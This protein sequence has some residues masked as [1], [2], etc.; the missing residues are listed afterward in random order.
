MLRTN[1]GRPVEFKAELTSLFPPRTPLTVELVLGGQGGGGRHVPMKLIDGAYRAVAVPFPEAKLPPAVK[2]KVERDSADSDTI[3]CTVVASRSGQDMSRKEALLFAEDADQPTLKVVSEGRFIRPHR[4]ETPV[5]SFRVLI[6]SGNP[7]CGGGSGGV[8]SFGA[9]PLV[10]GWKRF[11]GNVQGRFIRTHPF[12]FRPPRGQDFE[13]R[14]YI[15]GV[16][17][18]DR[19]NEYNNPLPTVEV[20]DGFA[21]TSP[22]L[23][24]KYPGLITIDEAFVDTGSFRG[25]VRHS[26]LDI[27]FTGRLRV[28]ECEL[29]KNTSPG[30][31]EAGDSVIRRLAVDFLLQCKATKPGVQ[32]P[33]PVAGMLRIRSSYE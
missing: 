5:N 18:R 27:E 32:N 33:P 6:P 30:V 15:L 2:V 25:T 16:Y 24:R 22:E 31:L 20:F 8:H 13:A 23:L 21:G 11:D 4:S 29:D 26:K 17:D 1:K 12:T 3:R 7:L 10:G 19:R 14:E 28:W 9:A